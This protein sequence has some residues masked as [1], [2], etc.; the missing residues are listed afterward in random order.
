MLPYNKALQQTLDPAGRSTA[1]DHPTASS[2]AE[3]R[4]YADH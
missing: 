1:A 4:R 3:R 2:A